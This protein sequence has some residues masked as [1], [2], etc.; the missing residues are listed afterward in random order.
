[1]AAGEATRKGGS[2]QLGVSAVYR[3]RHSGWSSRWRSAG[4]TRWK[5][6]QGKVERVK[7]LSSIGRAQFSEVQQALVSAGTL[8]E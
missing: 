1:M 3:R 7:H 2:A 5:D 6:K 4:E 8:V